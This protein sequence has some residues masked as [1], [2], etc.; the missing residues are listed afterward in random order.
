MEIRAKQLEL[1]PQM[2]GKASTIPLEDSAYP[3]QLESTSSLALAL[4]WFKKWMRREEHSAST[5]QTI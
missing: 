3:P 1:F 5:C 2:E 4:H